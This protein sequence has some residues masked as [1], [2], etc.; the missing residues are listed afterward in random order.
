MTCPEII[1][2]R[3]L[4]RVRFEN[5]SQLHSEGKKLIDGWFRR[6]WD[7]FQTTPN[8][9]FEPFIFLWFAFNGWAACVTDRDKDFEIVDA[10]A[11]SHKMNEDFDHLLRDANSQLNSNAT[12][13]SQLL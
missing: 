10:L 8:E 2:N 9:I 6:A 13:F 5:F 11:A 1:P 7:E 3:Q 4:A 12:I